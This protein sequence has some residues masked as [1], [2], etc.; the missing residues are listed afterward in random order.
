LRQLLLLLLLFL[1]VLVLL[2]LLRLLAGF[3]TLLGGIR[4]SVG[5]RRFKQWLLLLLAVLLL[6]QRQQPG[7]AH[8]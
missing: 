1:G 4:C 2:L 6:Q 7:W 3:V 5:L 8:S